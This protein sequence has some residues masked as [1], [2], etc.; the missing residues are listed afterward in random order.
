MGHISLLWSKLGFP[1]SRGDL[2]R[3]VD[4][5]GCLWARPNQKYVAL[6]RDSPARKPAIFRQKSGIFCQAF[7]HLR[8]HYGILAPL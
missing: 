2:D 4:Y 7:F 8:C 1:I 3:D 6:G 5:P